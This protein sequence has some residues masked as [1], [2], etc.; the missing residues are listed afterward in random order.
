MRVSNHWCLSNLLCWGESSEGFCP[1][2]LSSWRQGRRTER[3][4]P[5][6]ARSSHPQTVAI[7]QLSSHHGDEIFWQ[8]S[9]KLLHDFDK[10]QED[11]CHRHVH[12]HSTIILIFNPSPHSPS[13]TEARMKAPLGCQGEVRQKDRRLQTLKRRRC[14]RSPSC[15]SNLYNIYTSSI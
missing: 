7:L 4:Q 3:P 1:A 12:Y 5:T 15:K 9:S 8:I 10:S 6:E 14:R 2:A 11:C 13:P